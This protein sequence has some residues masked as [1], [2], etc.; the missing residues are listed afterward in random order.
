MRIRPFD[1]HKCEFQSADPGC[2]LW[3]GTVLS[4]PVC[5][6]F[7]GTKFIKHKFIKQ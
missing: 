3:N 6:I 1:E 5:A 2:A 7:D 4:V